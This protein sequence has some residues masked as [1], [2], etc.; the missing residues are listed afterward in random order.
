[1]ANF[2]V[3]SYGEVVVYATQDGS[4]TAIQVS[5][6]GTWTPS[7]NPSATP[8]AA[9]SPMPSLSALPTT[10]PSGSPTASPSGSPTMTALIPSGVTPAPVSTE[11]IIA[12]SVAPLR[13]PSTSSEHFAHALGHFAVDYQSTVGHTCQTSTKQS[14]VHLCVDCFTTFHTIEETKQLQQQFPHCVK[15]SATTVDKDSVDI[16]NR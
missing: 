12:P 9:L 2:A 5:V 7:S 6:D 14:N 13:G 4:V 1:M 10:P 15:P 11:P 8:T 3:S 16:V